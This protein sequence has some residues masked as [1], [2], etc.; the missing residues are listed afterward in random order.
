M[1]CLWR[2]ALRAGQAFVPSLRSW[3]EGAG[4]TDFGELGSTELAE[5]RSP[6]GG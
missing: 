2:Q 3:G 1:S 4:S 6:K 5:V